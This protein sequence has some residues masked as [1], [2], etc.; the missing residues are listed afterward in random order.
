MDVIVDFRVRPPFGGYLNSN[1]YGERERTIRMVRDQGYAPSQS[2]LGADWASFVQ[3]A[4]EA[5]I[6]KCIVPGRF[7][8]PSYGQISNAD[9]AAV[10]SKSAGLCVSFAAV[11]VDAPDAVDQLTV[12]IEG[13]GLAGLTLDPGFLSPARYPDDPIFER[14]YRR[15]SELRRPVAITSSG[16]A[17]PDI[18]YA[19]P[20]RIDRVAASFPDL[21][22]VVV[23]AGWPWLPQIF[24]VAFRRPNVFLSP[25]MYMINMPGAQMYV[26][27]ANGVLSDRI[28]FGSSYPFIPMKEA[29]AYYSSLPFKSSVL[30]M[31]MGG[32]AARVL[33]LA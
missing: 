27:A 8:T 25:D 19:D 10:A 14:L 17:G 29:V 16:H 3:E 30:P 24:G 18:G 9:Q 22:I 26:E 12:A 20:V 28:F 15:C 23:H 21:P 13:L 5:G 32:N 31:V 1:I 4:A 6:D 2:L 7:T 33:Q 11:D